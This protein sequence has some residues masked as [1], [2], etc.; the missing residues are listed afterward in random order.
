MS[1]PSPASLE[2]DEQEFMCSHL[3]IPTLFQSD[4][5]TATYPTYLLTRGRKREEPSRLNRNLRFNFDYIL[6]AGNH[7]M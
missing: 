3:T 6:M 5:P 2:S 4:F 7:V 1:L